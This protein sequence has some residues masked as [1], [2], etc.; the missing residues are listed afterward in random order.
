M[1][2]TGETATLIVIRWV[3]IFLVTAAAILGA[4]MLG[5]TSRAARAHATGRIIP[6]LPA[7]L[8]NV[9]DPCEQGELVAWGFEG[10]RGLAWSASS[11]RLIVVD[12]WDTVDVFTPNEPEIRKRIRPLA[13]LQICPD[14]DCEAVDHR[15]VAVD[16]D[17]QVL[18]GDLHQGRLNVFRAGDADGIYVGSVAP[19]HSWQAIAGIAIGKDG[20]RFVTDQRPWYDEN[21]GEKL[22]DKL[23]A[24]YR[25]AKH[26][27]P[28]VIDESLRYPSG[29]AVTATPDDTFLYVA[30]SDSRG[31]SWHVYRKNGRDDLWIA[32]GTLGVDPAGDQTIPAF[33]GLAAATLPDGE[34]VVFAAG[35]RGVYIFVGRALA[36]RID[37]DV[38]VSGITLGGPD[39]HDLY[40]LG[41][42]RLYK[43]S[44]RNA[45]DAPR[46][47]CE[48]T[49]GG[50][51]RK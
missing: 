9:L 1:S 44:M 42:R 35:S 31:T 48:D 38:P 37:L 16:A 15:G 40:V 39:V 4:S 14:D 46:N 17:G 7:K 26:G 2:S 33:R 3:S 45:G 5:L 47:R 51:Q 21:A 12:S 13:R 34:P 23:G 49:R 25:I 30:D 32:D 11:N 27:E 6:L 36:G 19:E 10:G 22:P 24:V 8:D 28:V 20:E 43:F 29:V 18:L 50:P 41:G